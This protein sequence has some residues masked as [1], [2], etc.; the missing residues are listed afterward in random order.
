MLRR[1]DFLRLVS[2]ASFSTRHWRLPIDTRRPRALRQGMRVGIVAPAGPVHPRQLQT[3]IEFFESLGL[4]VVLGRYLNKGNGYLAAPDRDRA[5]E[6]S[7]FL[8]RPDIDAV[9]C[10]RGGYGVLRILPLLDFSALAACTKPVIGYSDITALLIAL[11]QR[12]GLITFHGPMASSQF[13]STTAGS[14]IATLFQFESEYV[15]G[16]EMQLTYTDS[17]FL[18]IIQGTAEGKLLGGNLSVFCSLLGTPYE[19]DTRDCILFFEDVGEEPYKIDRMFTQLSLAGKLEGARGIILGAFTKQ[20]PRSN[21]GEAENT[22]SAII[23]IVAEQCAQHR[24]PLLANFPIGHIKS[25]ITLPIG[26]R[27]VLNATERTLR[28]IEAPVGSTP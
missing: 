18:P 27:A 2:T 5:A 21:E 19:P 28:I 8:L 16:A 3:G 25:K 15:E 1:R 22:G 12:T 10:A 23:Q 13:D 24:I 7:E 20:S 11:N 17:R 6:L 9:V 26:A 4:R 14:F